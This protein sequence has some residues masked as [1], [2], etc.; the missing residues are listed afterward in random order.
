MQDKI[1]RKFFLGF[2]QIHILHHAGQEP[3]YGVWMLEELKRHG[4]ELSPGTLY[5]ILHSMASSKLLEMDEKLV[6][7]KIRKYYRTTSFGSDVLLEAKKRAAELFR[8]T[9]GT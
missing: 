8:E 6:D 7:G 3:I 1:M 5:P 2:I 4:Y 9:N